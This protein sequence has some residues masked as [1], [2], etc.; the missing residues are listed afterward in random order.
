MAR[1]SPV[2]V[3]QFDTELR[4]VLKAG[5]RAGNSAALHTFLHR[6]SVFVVIKRQPE[7]ATR[8]RE[9]ERIVS[10]SEDRK[11]RRAAAAGIGALLAEAEEA[12]RLAARP[13]SPPTGAPGT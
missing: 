6:W 11:E 2:S 3:A 10:E 7:R 4:Q 9:F 13:D 12:V 1:L 5:A 8:L